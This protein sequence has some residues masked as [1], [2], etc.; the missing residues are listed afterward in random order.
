MGHATYSHESRMSPFAFSVRFARVVQ[1]EQRVFSLTI[2]GHFDGRCAMYP[3]EPAG[4]VESLWLLL[5]VEG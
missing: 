1:R 3:P 4:S 2:V 5:D